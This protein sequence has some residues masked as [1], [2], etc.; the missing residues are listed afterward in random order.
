MGVADWSQVKRNCALS[1]EEEVEDHVFQAALSDNQRGFMLYDGIA[2]YKNAEVVLKARATPVEAVQVA[3]CAVFRSD[4]AL[5]N[6]YLAAIR[7]ATAVSAI[8]EI[9]KWDAGVKSIMFTGPGVACVLDEWNQWRIRC[10]DVIFPAPLTRFSFER[11][12]GALWTP[13]W[14]KDDDTMFLHGVQGYSGYGA[15]VDYSFGAPD[16]RFVRVND[17][18][19]GH[20]A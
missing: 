7:F 5:D 11:K 13:L 9:Q 6:G 14:Q 1:I 8:L 19:L 15:Y 16:P 3:A 2:N 17:V 20:M 4:A 18:E 10:W 12:D